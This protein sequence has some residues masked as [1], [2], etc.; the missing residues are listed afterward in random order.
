VLTFAADFTHYGETI[1]A[2]YAIVEV[3]YN[4]TLPG[5]GTP[6]WVG[7]AGLVAVRRRR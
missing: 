3:R 7:F 1:L 2:N 6:W 5:P 4:T